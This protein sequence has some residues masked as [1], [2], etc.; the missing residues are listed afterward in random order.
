MVILRVNRK[1]K[2]LL[3]GVV[4]VVWITLNVTGITIAAATNNNRRRANAKM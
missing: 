1:K 3:I 4:V 2:F